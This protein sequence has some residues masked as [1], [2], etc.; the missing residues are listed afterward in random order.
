MNHVSVQTK[1]DSFFKPALLR[2]KTKY[3][4]WVFYRCINITLSVYSFWI[5]AVQWHFSYLFSWALLISLNF[6]FICV[7]SCYSL[8]FKATCCCLIQTPPSIRITEGLLYSDSL[9]QIGYGAPCSRSHCSVLLHPP[10][11]PWEVALF[12]RQRCLPPGHRHANEHI[13]FTPPRILLSTG[14]VFNIWPQFPAC[15]DQAAYRR[16][17]T[18]QHA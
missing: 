9:A 4:F 8:S 13:N 6:P 16:L 11:H 17:L 14:W 7:Q 15:V 1:L 18:T 3:N 12:V 10:V 5:K 2:S